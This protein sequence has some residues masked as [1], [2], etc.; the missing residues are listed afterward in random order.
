MRVTNITQQKRDPAKYNIYLD[1]TYVF[2]LPK[3]DMAYFK[4]EEGKDVSEETVAFIQENLIYIRAQDTA[5]HYIGYKMRTVE[6]VRKKLQE[7]EFTPDVIDAVLAFLEK[8]KYTDDLVYAQKYIKE[9]LRLRPKSGYLLKM[10][11]RQRGVA[12]RI[13][14]LALDEI[15]PDEAGDAYGWLRKK[16]KGEPVVLDEKKRRQLYGFLGRKGYSYDIIKEAFCR[17]ERG[18]DDGESYGEE[19]AEERLH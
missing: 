19:E 3:Q 11:L 18:D 16:T 9:R 4:I 14:T 2:A 15:Q 7:K 5:L 12:E 6:E 10:E 17:L 8:F 13:C 1:G